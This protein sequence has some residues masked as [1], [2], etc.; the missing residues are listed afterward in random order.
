[1]INYTPN[2]TCS[3]KMVITIKIYINYI[4]TEVFLSQT[5]FGFPSVSVGKRFV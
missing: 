1:M 3:F 4:P 5:P 2:I